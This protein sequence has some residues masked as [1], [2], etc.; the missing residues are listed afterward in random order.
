V[1]RAVRIYNLPIPE[2]H[3]K[4]LY[5]QMRGRDGQVDYEA[6]AHALKRK[7]ALGN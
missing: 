7:D 3:V 4:Q 2:A 5:A 6:F 1:K